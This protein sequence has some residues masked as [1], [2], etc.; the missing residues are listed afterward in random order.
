M[1]HALRHRP[2]DYG[3]TL[4]PG[5]WASVEGLLEALRARRPEWRSLAL[6][7]VLSAVERGERRRFEVRAERIRALYGHSVDVPLGRSAVEPPEVL[8]HGTTETA[9]ESILEDGLEPMGR[10]KVHLSP[11]RATAIAVGRRRTPDPALLRIDARAAH[12]DGVAFHAAGDGVW[13]SEPVPARFVEREGAD[14]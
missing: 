13:L 11:D 1:A 2:G 10:R 12:D 5:G 8:W 4:E 6:E 7:D 14:G 3:L 9:A